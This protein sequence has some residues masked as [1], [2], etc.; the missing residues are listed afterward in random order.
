MD[1]FA[2]YPGLR[3]GSSGPSEPVSLSLGLLLVLVLPPLP[4]ML[5][6]PPRCAFR[7]VILVL[8]P[9]EVFA[10]KDCSALE[11]PREHRS[12]VSADRLRPPTPRDTIDGNRKLA[13]F[14]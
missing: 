9:E 13:P 1:F 6:D 3:S 2:Q 8:F 11:A 12:G 7:P 5:G 10:W 4:R 14:S